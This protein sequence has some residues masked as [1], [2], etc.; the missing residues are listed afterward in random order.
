MQMN[1]HGKVFCGSAVKAGHLRL[2]AFT[3]I[4]LLVVIA[5]I[6]LLVALLL[7]AIQ[8]SREASRR[9]QC[10]NNVKQIMLA[11]SNHVLARG[12][13]PSGGSK[14]WTRIEDYLSADGVPFG[15]QKQGLSWAFQILPYLEEGGCMSFAIRKNYRRNLSRCTTARRAAGQRLAKLRELFWWTMRR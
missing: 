8:A 1:N 15:P 7:P 3:L 13:F 2:A 9:A 4:E 5:I 10:L 11:M 12:V 6:G 14:Y